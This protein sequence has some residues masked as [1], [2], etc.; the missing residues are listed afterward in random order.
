VDEERLRHDQARAHSS[1]LRAEEVAL[2]LVDEQVTPRTLKFVEHDD[3]LLAR[4]TLVKEVEEP[5][6]QIRVVLPQEVPGCSRRAGQNDAAEH[7]AAEAS[8][9]SLELVSKVVKRIL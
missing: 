4:V 6:E 7:R 2:H 9:C 3:P 1:H 5:L 8:A